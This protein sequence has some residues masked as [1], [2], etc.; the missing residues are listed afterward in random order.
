EVQ[1]ASVFAR[2][3]KLGNIA[4]RSPEFFVRREADGSLNWAS[5][6]PKGEK[7]QTTT[8]QP[9]Q[10]ATQSHANDE[11]LKLRIEEVRIDD[12]QIHFADAAAP[13]PFKTDI[14]D[15]LVVFRKFALPQAD[16]ATLEVSF[17]TKFGESLKHAA[18]LFVSPLKIDGSLEVNGV[19][20]KNYS[21][22]YASS[23]GFDVQEGRFA[24]STRFLAAQNGTVDATISGLQASLNKLR[25]RMRGA[26]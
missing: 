16:P 14:T 25:L 12:G 8:S 11:S 5:V 26:N 6:V 24:L 1:S 17:G 23:V 15:L 2:D 20:P 13:T 9:S 19:K 10:E 22:Y 21:P 3:I 7:E 4:L 18:T